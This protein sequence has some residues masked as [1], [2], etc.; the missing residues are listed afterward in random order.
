MP[1]MPCSAM[2]RGVLG[3]VAHAEQAAVHH[4]MQGLDPAVHHLRISRLELD[5]VRDRKPGCGDRRARAA[6]GDELDAEVAQGA[7]NLDKAGL[8]EDR[9][10]SAPGRGAVGG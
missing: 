5:D 9:D 3:R 6:G 8:V 2:A 1:P 7:R 10:Q 4:R